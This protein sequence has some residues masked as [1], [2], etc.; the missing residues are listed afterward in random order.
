[1]QMTPTLTKVCLAAL[2]ASLIACQKS[3]NAPAPSVGATGH[4]TEPAASA[5]EDAGAEAVTKPVATPS[6]AAENWVLPGTLGPLTTRLELETRFGKTN[7]REQTFD[8]P[9]GSGSYS[10]LVVF[11]D[12]PHK[13]LELVQDAA[14]PDA[15]IVELRIS[16]PT[17]HWHDVNGLRPGMRLDELVKLNGAPI[18]FYGVGWDY[19][20]VV[21]DWHGGK[22]A[23]P[24]DADVFHR[25]VLT[26]RKGIGNV[27]LPVGDGSFRSDDSRYPALGDG[28][29]VGAVGISWPHEG[30]D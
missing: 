23:N 21:Q 24:V 15:P 11:P 22:L 30:E 28:L 25:V 2:L 9:E 13:R 20:G 1:M 4:Q 16:E 18:S 17:S 26:P 6:V 12:D 5:T 7:V 8:A 19:G 27:R 3:P 14:N 10:G 29:V